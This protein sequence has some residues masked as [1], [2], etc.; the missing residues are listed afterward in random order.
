MKDLIEIFYKWMFTRS[1]WP[2]LQYTTHSKCLVGVLVIMLIVSFLTALYYYKVYIDVNTYSRS[3]RKKWA[4]VG[5]VGMIICFVGCEL[6]LAYTIQ[7]PGLSA[8][9]GKSG[10]EVIKCSL[11]NSLL[12]YTIFYSLWSI[13]ISRMTKSIVRNPF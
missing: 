4:L 12:Y 6:W 11:F 5:M 3:Y 10:I 9:I 7:V 13:L 2:T 8:Y 1:E